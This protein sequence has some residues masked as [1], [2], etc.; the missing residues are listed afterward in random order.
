MSIKSQQR[1]QYQRL[2]VFLKKLRKDAGQT[3]EELARKL[4]VPQSYVYKS[5][6]AIRR[7][8][9]TEFVAWSRACGKSPV[10]A[11]RAFLKE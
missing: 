4:R 10:E 5:E 7:V 9:L 2:K 6:T 11:L 8:D 3:Q 1:P